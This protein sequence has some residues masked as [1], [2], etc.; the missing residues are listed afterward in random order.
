MKR[1]PTVAIVGRPNVGKSTLFNRI[2][3]RRSAIVHDLP[4]VTRDRN[5]AEA[6]WAGYEFTLVDTGGYFDGSATVIEQAVIR[7]INEA[8]DEASTIVF[9]V[10]GQTGAT[11]MDAE[12]AKLLRRSSKPV[13]LA[14]NKIDN[15]EQQVATAEFFQ[16]GLGQPI[17]VSAATGRQTGDFLDAVVARLPQSSRTDQKPA[18]ASTE[19]SAGADLRLAIVGRPNVGKSSLVNALLGS[20]KVIVTEIP[21]TTRDSTDTVLRYKGKKIVLIDT[22]GLR[23]TSRVNEAIEFYS[24]VRTREALRRCNV[25]VVLTDAT[26]GLTDQDLH[27]VEEIAKLKRGVVLAVNKWDRIE[28]DATT[29][30]QVEKT[31][32]DRLRV[33][34]FIPVILVSA[35]TRKRIYKLVDLAMTVHCERQ[36]LIRTSELNNFLQE[37]IKKYPP[38]SMDRREVKLNYCAQV[39]SNPPVFAI[40]CNHPK[41]IRRNYRQYLENKFRA[42]FGFAGVP[43]TFSFR[44]K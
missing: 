40:F 15:S 22:A 19:S 6:E 30:K 7:Q 16:L 12:I 18:T 39:K 44:K 29:A 43:L 4:G 17:P 38:P 41:S 21:G 3:R 32:L 35:L 42:R 14:V 33:Y 10:D 34:D 37:C 2:I 28:K 23:K 8:I 5:Y 27:I 24:T 13:L 31:L 25:A 11:A 1:K 20:D 9:V 26:E 36:R